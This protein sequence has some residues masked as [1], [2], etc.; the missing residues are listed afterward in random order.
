[1]KINSTKYKVGIKWSS[2]SG[3]ILKWF[4]TLGPDHR[5]QDMQIPIE[6]WDPAIYIYRFSSVID[7]SKIIDQWKTQHKGKKLN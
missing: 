5:F 2:D 1:M 4:P 3:P 6:L 7:S